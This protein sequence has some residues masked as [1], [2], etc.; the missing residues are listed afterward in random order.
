MRSLKIQKLQVENFRN[1]SSDTM[2]GF[3]PGVNCILGENGNGKT[4]ILEAIYFLITHKSFRKN[5]RF[6]Q[7]LGL[8]GEYSEIYMSAIFSEGQ[9]LLPISGKI[10]EKESEWYIEG[11]PSK[12]KLEVG[13]V[14]IN[15]FDGQNFHT[16]SSTR[17]HWVDTHLSQLDSDYKKNLKDY[18]Y[19]LKLRNS[20]LAKKPNKY[21]E[22]IRAIDEKM[23]YLAVEVEKRRIMFLAELEPFCEKVFKEIFDYSYSIKISINSQVAHLDA[24][25]YLKILQKN[26]P[27]DEL[28]KHTSCGVHKDDY[29]LL[30]N[31]LNSF[32]YCS[33][34]QQKISYLSLLFAYIEL[35]RYK[36][37]SSP[38]VL[39][40]DISGEL[41]RCRSVRLINYLKESSFQT[42]LTTANEKFGEELEQ[43]NGANSI[44]VQ[45]GSI[46]QFA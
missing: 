35:F 17:R 8:D 28:L 7:I 31:G 15:P 14:F 12:R 34:G 30:F 10:K 25:S 41:D 29:V 3:S 4:N 5:A 16:N 2:I 40:D 32:D 33:L 11:K 38:I 27:K 39:L 44:I 19:S 20:L 9:K 42:L 1:L 24:E 21:R 36:F 6:P 23:V 37:S 26:L 43:I 18:N 22:Q 45:S 46:S 13:V